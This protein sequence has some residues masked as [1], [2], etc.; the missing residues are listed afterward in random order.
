MES[1][2][3]TAVLICADAQITAKTFNGLKC[4]R[5]GFKHKLTQ[6]MAKFRTDT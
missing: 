2:E 4:T 1:V 5:L 6:T 3:E